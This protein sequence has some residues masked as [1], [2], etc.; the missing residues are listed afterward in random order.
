MITK[1]DAL[2]YH[3]R[4]RKG[5][6]EVVPTKPCSTQRDLGLAYTPGV[7][8]PCLEIEK[9]PALANEYTA[10]GNLVGVI[11]NGTAVLGLGNIGALAGKPVMEGKGV[12]FKRFADID[13]FDIE[14]DTLDPVKFCEAVKLLE[15]TFGGINLED[16]KAPECFY[17][18]KRLREEMN[19]PVFHDDQHGTAIIS[20]AAVINAAALTGKNLADLK[21]VISGAGAAAISC[22]EHYIRLGATRENMIMCDSKGVIYKGRT[23]G[24]NE[25]KARFAVDTKLRNIHE[26]MAGADVFI[27]LSGPN[28]IDQNDVKAMAKDPIVF[29]MANPDPEITYNEAKAA[30]PDIIMGTGRSDYPNQIN[31]VLGFPFIFLGAL[32]VQATSINEEMKVAATMALANLAKEDVPDEVARAYGVER[33]EF[34]RDYIIPKPFD[35]R[36][37]IWEAAAVAQA[38]METGVAQKTID[39][40]KYREELEGRLGKSRE[41]MRLLY[42][43]A[44]KNPKKIVYPEGENNRIIRASRLVVQEG[45]AKP[46]LLGREDIIRSKA[47]TLGVDLDGIEIINPLT[48]SKQDEYASRLYDIR[49]RKGVTLAQ[50]QRL[51][52]RQSYYGTLMVEVGDADGLVSGISQQYPETIRP[53]L[54]IIKMAPG[55]KHVAGLFLLIFKNTM[56]IFADVTVNIDTTPEILAEIAMM[57]ADTA[58]RFRM[59]P[60]VAM[61]S[62]SNFGSVSHPETEK[63]RRAVEILHEKAPDMIVDGEMNADLAVMPE[64]L[65]EHYPFSQLQESANVLIF[66]DLQ[67]GNIAY[68]LVHRLSG[69][70]AIGPILV[71]MKKPVHLLQVGSSEV[72]DVANMTALAVVDAQEIDQKKSK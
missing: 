35:P 15:P 18:E 70:E 41:F 32:D 63:V 49:K 26:A 60:K 43:R 55:V 42:N 31:N 17:I 22:C 61:L 54:Q 53:A 28:S 36:V 66:P 29:A 34:G 33:L 72:I 25:F 50:A 67:S 4:G 44:K 65:K 30:R 3:S 57:A 12:L 64:L 27:G 47:A 58:R 40:E 39:I 7:A 37:L 52:Q 71:G 68:K 45:I 16:I 6:I 56:K 5:K 21:F 38:A 8:I 23:D 14:V 24:M 10:K 2:E 46:I 51:V 19:I 69:A 9:N 11:S 59:D 20:G 48:S 1:E 62:F 13:V